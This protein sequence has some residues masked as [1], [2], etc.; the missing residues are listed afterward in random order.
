MSDGNNESNYQ[1]PAEVSEQ[2]AAEMAEL[3]AAETAQA[4]LEIEEAPASPKQ[5]RLVAILT[6]NRVLWITA[7]SCLALATTGLGL[8]LFYLAPVGVVTTIVQS[9]FYAQFAKSVGV[10]SPLQA[11]ILRRAKAG[12]V[13]AWIIAV[14]TIL[15]LGLFIGPM[16][17]S[18]FN[19]F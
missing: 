2:E 6:I 16:F 3:G 8:V 4:V 14:P 13:V 5:K 10:P 12:T 18:S 7:A 17:L 11:K 1:A 15:V 9:V 19:N